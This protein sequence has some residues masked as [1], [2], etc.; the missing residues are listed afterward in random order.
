MEGK[1]ERGGKIEEERSR[2]RSTKTGETKPAMTSSVA[3]EATIASAGDNWV[4]SD[5]RGRK[6]ECSS[7]QGTGTEAECRDSSKKGSFCNGD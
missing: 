5:G 7:G 4:C 1:Q 2:R 6:D 3:E